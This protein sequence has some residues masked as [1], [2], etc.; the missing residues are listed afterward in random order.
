[1]YLGL[2]VLRLSSKDFWQMTPKELSAALAAPQLSE[3][4]M[5][6]ASLDTLMRLFPDNR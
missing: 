6:R 5:D 4:M 2:G 3:T 1:M